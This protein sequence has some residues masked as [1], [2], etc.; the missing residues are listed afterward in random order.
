MRNSMW[1][2]NQMKTCS[3][4][5]GTVDQLSVTT[6]ILEEVRETWQQHIMITKR[7]AESAHDWMMKVYTWIV[8]P[9]NNV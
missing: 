7:H 1:E 8:N 9:E 6:C 5:L 4:A 2:N 3:N